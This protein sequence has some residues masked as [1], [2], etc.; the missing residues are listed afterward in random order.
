M[1]KE[2]HDLY[3]KAE[4][5]NYQRPAGDEKALTRRKLKRVLNLIISAR[6]QIDEGRSYHAEKNVN[7]ARVILS[8]VL[9][10]ELQLTNLK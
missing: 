9:G 1:I 8:E 6:V 3:R 7:Q 5:E 4:A 10:I 2:T